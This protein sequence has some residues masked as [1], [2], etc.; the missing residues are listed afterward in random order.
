MRTVLALLLAVLLPLPAGAADQ[1]SNVRTETSV[2][3]TALPQPT[4]SA[5]W[6]G[7]RLDVS[8]FN[9][10][11]ATSVVAAVWDGTVTAAAGG[12]HVRV[13]RA[14]SSAAES[15]EA[16]VRMVVERRVR[17]RW[18]RCDGE[19]ADASRT[20]G[21]VTPSSGEGITV[22]CRTKRGETSVPVRV[23]IAATYDAATAG[24]ADAFTIT[25]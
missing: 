21:G 6:T 16:T 25:G 13:E 8:G 9:L 11:G 18:H 22:V 24:L 23:R 3:G 19:G 10:P 1:R 2:A 4:V 17:G 20:V 15:G 14:A 12:A 5:A 7:N